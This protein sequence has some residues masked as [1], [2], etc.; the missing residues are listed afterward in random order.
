MNIK[1]ENEKKET[2]SIVEQIKVE[3]NETENE[4]FTNNHS[5]SKKKKPIITLVKEYIYQKYEI[6]FD[7]I[8]LK[9][10]WRTKGEIAFKELNEND[11]FCEL[12]ENNLKIAQNQ[13]WAIIYSNWTPQYNPLTEYF[14]NL[15]VWDG[16]TDYIAKLSSYLDIEDKEYFLKHFKKWLVRVIVCATD[17]NYFNKQ[18][19]LFVGDQ[20]NGKTTLQRFLCPKSL[21]RYFSE[22]LIDGK[23]ELI[24][25]TSS[26][27]ILMDELSKFDKKGI[28]NVKQLMTKT[29][30]NFRPPFA[31]TNRLFY[32]FCSF[33]GNTNKAEF[34]KDET[35]SVRFLCFSLKNIDFRYSKEINMDNVYSQTYALYKNGFQYDITKEE[36]I[37]IQRYNKKFQVLTTEQELINKYFEPAQKGEKGATFMTPTEVAEKLNELTTIK[38]SPV[39]IGNGMIF[40]GFIRQQYRK[41]ES[42]HPVYGYWVR[43]T[44]EYLIKTN[45]NLIS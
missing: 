31:K 1:N 7:T 32:R 34:L 42:A 37:E 33:M 16:Q 30:V 26:L 19:L 17:P 21:S 24:T 28:E 29:S 45:T 10:E 39:N 5:K 41:T 4:T 9:Y 22:D 12:H 13:L 23:D 27:F 15:P 44:Q 3:I 6:R 8:S 35:G 43:K 18:M 36:A 2:V 20:N 14:L 11:L 38:I 25:L 40:L